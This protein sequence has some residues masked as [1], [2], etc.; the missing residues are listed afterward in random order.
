MADA[1]R[2]TS[3]LL[4]ANRGE[5]AIRIA[6]SAAELGVHTVA[7]YPADDAECLHVRSADEARALPGTGA[8]A[9]LDV[10]QIISAARAS[11]CDALHPGYGFLSENAAFARRCAEA[12]VRFVGP[13]PEILELLGDKVQARA[14]A[15]RTDVPLLGGSRE[16]A[17]LEDARKF[18]ESLP[19]GG[20][21]LIKAVA[22]GGGRGLRAVES[23]DALDEAYARCQSE[24]RAAFG[25]PAV[26]VEQRMPRA[27]HIEVQVVG[28]G[29]GAVAQLGERDC[30]IQRRH[31]KLVE[32][33]PAPDVPGALLERIRAAALRMARALR[34]DSL[35]TFEFL[36]D[37]RR[38]LDDA[39]PFAFIE[40]NPR[41]Q[42]EH[43]VTEEVTGIDLVRVQLELAAGRTLA[44]L[45]L[46][47]DEVPAPRGCAIQLRINLETMEAD[48]SARPSAGTLAALALPS[49]PGVR[50]DTCA[51]AGYRTSA[52]YDSL[53]AKLIVRST[54]SALDVAARKAERAL[55]ELR[56]E[57]VPSNAGF[58]RALLR[59]PAFLAGD[60]HTR[61]L[62]EHGAR[63][64]AQVTPESAPVENSAASRRLAGARIDASDPLAVL[65]YG[66]SARTRAP[67]ERAVPR[68]PD[69]SVAL[70]APL[71]G[72]VVSLGVAEGEA[73]RA[74]QA[75]LVMESMKMEYAYRAP[76]A[77]YVEKILVKEG[78]TLTKGQVFFALR[79]Q[80]SA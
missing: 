25:S 67:A 30:S 31:Q 53:L 72:T 9:Y 24:A 5:I 73:V 1:P 34:Y 54:A 38:P 71:Q 60:L 15:E 49:G 43:T 66:Q 44:E 61:F 29:S 65:S 55:A 58:L 63:I 33:A 70:E 13:R 21:M 26:Y 46:S 74:G 27:R 3:R 8:A 76:S 42:V 50:V 10:E 12:D 32:I 11:G 64:H 22:G 78:D 80:R 39:S 4:I 56:I 77:V 7:V 6:R 37:A 17:S 36:V 16:P 59:D 62:E 20:S 41:L 28:D 23:L 75:L 47:Q 52:L 35:G 79:E 48:G 19:A 57:G 40:A 69:G 68:A 2:P 18:F 14:L 45:R 51:Y